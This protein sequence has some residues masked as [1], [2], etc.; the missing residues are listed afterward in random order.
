VVSHSRRRYG[1]AG[2]GVS[3]RFAVAAAVFTVGLKAVVVNVLGINGG[4]ADTVLTDHERIGAV[5]DF[6]P[7]NVVDVAV[8]V[9]CD[10][11]IAVTVGAF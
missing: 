7:L 11:H 10:A 4:P 2:S 9:V 8:Q 5:N 3:Q 1:H 6:T